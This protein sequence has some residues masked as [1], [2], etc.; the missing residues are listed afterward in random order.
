MLAASG[1]SNAQLATALFISVP[2][3]KDH[4]HSILRKAGLDS[5]AQLIAAW[6]GG[7]GEAT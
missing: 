3:V 5:R 6:Y 4:M 2:T 1:Y 7:L